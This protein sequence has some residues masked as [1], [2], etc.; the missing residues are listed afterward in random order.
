MNSLFLLDEQEQKKVQEQPHVEQD[1]GFS[2]RPSPA[3]P[4]SAKKPVGARANNGTPNRRLSLNANQNG[5][6]SIAKEGERRGSLNR[7]AAPTNYVAISKEEAAS[8]PGS[9]AA[10]H[11]QASP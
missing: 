8:S 4:V 2:T 1:S 9:G 3:R 7:T 10:D 5:S 11:V 6:R